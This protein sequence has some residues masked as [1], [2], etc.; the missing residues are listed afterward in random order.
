LAAGLGFSSSSWKNFSRADW[1][2]IHPRASPKLAYEIKN[3]AKRK[4]RGIIHKVDERI[5]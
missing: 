5:L 2:D 3:F 4:K 1:R